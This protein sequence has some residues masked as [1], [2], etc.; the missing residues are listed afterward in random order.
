[1]PARALLYLLLGL[2]CMVLDLVFIL[3]SRDHAMGL[4]L[5]ILAAIFFDGCFALIQAR[6][7]RQELEEMWKMRNDAVGLISSFVFSPEVEQRLLA[8]GKR[9][10]DARRHLKDF[11]EATEFPGEG[12][13]NSERVAAFRVSFFNR[14]VTVQHAED[15]LRKM[16][17]AAKNYCGSMNVFGIRPTWEHYLPDHPWAPADEK[18][19]RLK[20]SAE[21]LEELTEPRGHGAVVKT[22]L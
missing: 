13:S 15:A 19:Q 11:E 3:T 12:L 10:A 8:A 21:A 14:E 22:E 4:P 17:D 9:L 6:K 16:F 2:L 18:L 1:M 7:T 20:N 5:A